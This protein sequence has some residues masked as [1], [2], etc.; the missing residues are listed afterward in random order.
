MGQLE[1]LD[2]TP[3]KLKPKAGMAEPSLWVG[4]LV[5]WRAPGDVVRTVELHPGLNI[6]CSPDPGPKAADLGKSGALGHGAG[7]TLFCRLL[8]YC[9]GEST[10][11]TQDM[12]GRIRRAFPEGYVGA[13]VHLGGKPWAV[14]RPLGL[15]RRAV[16]VQGGDL[17][18]ILDQEGPYEAFLEALDE[19]FV[20]PVRKQCELRHSLAWE[21]ILSWLARDQECRLSSPLAWRTTSAESGSPTLGIPQ[22]VLAYFARVLLGLMSEAEN[23]ERDRLTEIGR[24]KTEAENLVTQFRGQLARLH[25]RLQGERRLGLADLE[26]TSGL[27]AHALAVAA[28]QKVD[29]LR[30]ALAA[31]E[32]ESN[33]AAVQRSLAEAA[34]ELGTYEALAK[35]EQARVKLHHDFVDGADKDLAALTAEEIKTRLG[36][37]VC[38]V[39]CVPID[40]AFAEGCGL[41]LAGPGLEAVLDRKQQRQALRDRHD[42]EYREAK[43]R[44]T[45]QED[46]IKAREAR[47]QQIE[48]QLVAERGR[49]GQHR[50]R[51]QAELSAAQRDLWSAETY[52]QT[53]AEL[54]KAKNDVQTLEASARKSREQAQELRESSSKAKL[55]LIELLQNVVCEIL[56]STAKAE[57]KFGLRDLD[58]ALDVDGDLSS[59][60]LNGLKTWCFDV[61]AII[62]SVEGHAFLPTMLVH[63]SPRDGDLGVS[64]YHKYFL[65][66][67]ALE[68]RL[69]GPAFQYIVTSTTEPPRDLSG[70]DKVVL[71]LDGTEGEGRFLKCSL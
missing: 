46:A 35:Q 3:L 54:D 9:L 69:S 32:S 28:R 59:V 60:A 16:A 47:L 15:R 39:C 44:L 26:A 67:A 24:R 71:R 38:P 4:R 48:E 42:K 65:L 70:P 37:E 63:D 68:R 25:A 22:E 19:A 11:A 21:H 57:L 66:M 20:S 52:S 55:R 34:R 27:V 41:V 62:A 2:R 7:K 29:E 53:V 64:L 33:I 12:T 6:V 45:E 10:F 43:R 61:A 49:V 31:V 30:N 18:A 1:L 13:L 58:V 23:Q 51:L 36:T 5:I 17:A 14:A 40:N 50:E 8:R 56:G